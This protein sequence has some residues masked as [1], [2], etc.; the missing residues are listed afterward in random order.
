MSTLSDRFKQ[1]QK[2]REVKGIKRE[3]DEYH[4]DEEAAVRLEAEAERAERNLKAKKRLERATCRIQDARAKRQKFRQNRKCTTSIIG[5]VLWP[6]NQKKGKKT[7]PTFMD[8][9]LGRGP[10]PKKRSRSKRK[11]SF[12]DGLF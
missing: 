11:D 6:K 7:S 2:E 10:A 3:L 8:D 4:A 12:L 1:F 5:D 9:L